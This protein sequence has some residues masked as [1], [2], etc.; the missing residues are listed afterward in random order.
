ESDPND[1][2]IN[3]NDV[4]ACTSIVVQA[5]E[6]ELGDV[7]P[8]KDH[9]VKPTKTVVCQDA[10]T[11]DLVD[12]DAVPASTAMLFNFTI[13]MQR[14]ESD[15]VAF[16]PVSNIKDGL[17]IG[18][19]Y[20]ADS[21]VLDGV[22]FNDDDLSVL[23]EPVKLT[24]IPRSAV[25]YAVEDAM[26]K[27]A[28]ANTKFGADTT[29]QVQSSLADNIRAFLWFDVSEISAGTTIIDAELE[30]C[31]PSNLDITRTYDAHLVTGPW[32]DN[33]IMWSNQP[34]VAAAATES[35]VTDPGKKC[36]KWV[37]LEPDIQAWV[38]GTTNYGWRI[39][40]SAEDSAT[41]YTAPFR[42]LED[43]NDLNRR[44][45]LRK[46]EYLPGYWKI[47]WK[48]SPT[49]DFEHG[50][51]R[52]L[53]FQATAT[54]DDDTRYCNLAQLKSKVDEQTGMTAPVTVGTPAYSGCPGGGLTTSKTAD[55]LVIFPGVPTFVT[56]HITF[57]NDDILAFDRA[58]KIEDYL[59]L[60]F[61]YVVGSATTPCS[62]WAN[63][64]ATCPTYSPDNAN[65]GSP[66]GYNICD[67]EPDISTEPDGRLKL[68]WHNDSSDNGFNPGLALCHDYPM[69][70][71]TTYTQTFQTLV[72]L[73]QSGSYYN[74]FI[75][76]LKDSDLFGG[77]RGLKSLD[78]VYSWPT[79]GTI[80]PDFDFKVETALTTLYTNVEIVSAGMKV[81]SHHWK[82]HR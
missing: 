29:L 79:G 76:K 75:V 40:D 23:S 65:F 45:R 60:G 22:P 27:E 48:L 16:V 44:P 42:S 43:T 64:P 47:E 50:E 33:V 62:S 2:C 56:Y 19:F 37:D 24:E 7:S 59:P 5:T 36:V 28:A 61:S 3:V 34:T 12:C 26:V 6:G 31:A 54:L 71:G 49:L 82:K 30:L 58:D 72:T 63:P 1:L 41:A 73:T 11:L 17:D 57:T 8:A 53:T 38:D 67:L 81:K 66:A 18:F 10:G 35:V 55:P 74:E 51:K 13:T 25:R 68:K 4:D 80:V 52:A 46:A 77:N 21:S 15:D 14:L 9:M 69:P 32:Q 70:L 78:D 39:S 20:V